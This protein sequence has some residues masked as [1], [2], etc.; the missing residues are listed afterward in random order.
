MDAREKRTPFEYLTY[1][2][3][4][5][6]LLL[7]LGTGIRAEEAVRCDM[8]DVGPYSDPKTAEIYWGLRLRTQKGGGPEKVAYLDEIRM[9]AF[10]R[11]R[12]AF[13]LPADVGSKEE[14]G[15]ILSPLTDSNSSSRKAAAR[16]RRAAWRS[17]RTRQSAWNIVKGE[18]RAAARRLRECGEDA[19]A[20]LME[21]VSTHW[22]RHT[23]A[24]Q[25]MLSGAELRLV[26]DVMR[27][28]DPRT[29]MRYTHLEFHDVARKLRDLRQQ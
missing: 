21:R 17:I 14:Y 24:T 23:L 9:D 3:N 18:F 20:Q 5:F 28:K 4:R 8:T 22:L 7:F 16:R 19:G 1:Y 10:R 27:H 13:G 6:V 11:Y 12:E 29:T 15:L 26:S 2:R 25:L